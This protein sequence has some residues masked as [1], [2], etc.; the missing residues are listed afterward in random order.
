MRCIRLHELIAL[1]VVGSDASCA[2]MKLQSV[3]ELNAVSRPNRELLY[4]T[5]MSTKNVLTQQ[6]NLL[7][8][9][10]TYSKCCA[11][12]ENRSPSMQEAPVPERTAALQRRG[13]RAAA[14]RRAKWASCSSSSPTSSSS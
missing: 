5:T 7:A 3:F 13:T 8:I 14:A 12:G 6:S 10:Y 2:D 4:H 9:V 1:S 11:G